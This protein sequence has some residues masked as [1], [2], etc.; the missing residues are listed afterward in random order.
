MTDS[1][2]GGT[3]TGPVLSTLCDAALLDRVQARGPDAEAACALLLDR[4]R[5]SLYWRCL[6]RLGNGHDADDALQETLLRA[7]QGLHGFEGRSAVRTWLF[8]I[9]DNECCSF[10]RRNSRH[11][12]AEHLRSLIQIHEEHQRR[13]ASI[14]GEQARMVNRTLKQ[15]PPNAREVL[16][17]RFFRGASFDEIARTLDISLSA[18]KMRVYRALDLFEANFPDAR[19]SDVGRGKLMAA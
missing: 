9:A 11:Q 12:R 19:G 4:H 1:D 6:Q 18:A 5:R 3:E 8:A 17:L 13:W 2:Q 14:D 15:L 10:V 16:G 7:L